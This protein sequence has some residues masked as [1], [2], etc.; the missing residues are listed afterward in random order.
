MMAPLRDDFEAIHQEDLSKIDG[1]L[2]GKKLGVIPPDPWMKWSLLSDLGLER[3]EILH[4][5]YP[6]GLEGCRAVLIHSAWPDEGPWSGELLPTWGPKAREF[7]R[8]NNRENGKIAPVA[9]WNLE[10]PNPFTR[11]LFDHFK[12]EAD[13][14]AT[15]DSSDDTN[16]HVPMPASYALFCRW[17]GGKAN[18]NGHII[19]AGRWYPKHEGR[20]TLLR[21]TLKMVDRLGVQDRFFITG[22]GNKDDW[23]PEFHPFLIGWKM[24][25]P[26]LAEYYGK[27]AI[28]INHDLWPNCHSMRRP[29]YGMAGLPI[30]EDALTL[31]RLILLRGTWDEAASSAQD[32]AFH[33]C[34]LTLAVVNI[35]G[36]LRERGAL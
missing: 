4:P 19:F 9:Y 3:V 15:V 33:N 14:V 8:Y 11:H 20:V 1:Y 35:L 34:R 6:E 30:A 27:C 22:W 28:G 25:F 23:P 2:A 10:G 7:W 29:C 18:F 12:A 36:A 26:E 5:D 31:K 16:L 21:E 13:L 32:W 24:A 17:A